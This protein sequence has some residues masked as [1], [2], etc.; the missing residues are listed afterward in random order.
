MLGERVTENMD[1]A[2][3][4]ECRELPNGGDHASRKGITEKLIQHRNWVARTIDAHLPARFLMR[5]VKTAPD[6]VHR[7]LASYRPERSPIDGQRP[8]SP[9][10]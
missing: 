6:S 9:I 4:R 8:P 5:P 10:I 3:D 7:V 2:L 1:A